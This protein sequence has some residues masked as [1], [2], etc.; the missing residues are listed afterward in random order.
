MAVDS[1]IEEKIGNALIRRE[2]MR[3]E[4]VDAVLKLQNAGDDRLFGEIAVDI[5]FLDVRE[6]ID[7]LRTY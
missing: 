7:Y 4:E 3:Q 2:A 5:G 1:S 6:L